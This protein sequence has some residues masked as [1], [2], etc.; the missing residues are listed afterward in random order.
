MLQSTSIFLHMLAN[1]KYCYCN[2][3][4]YI[5]RYC[6]KEKTHIR[7]YINCHSVHLKAFKGN[8]A[9]NQAGE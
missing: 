4:Q 6:N 5:R 9:A 8:N 7:K 1:I 3:R 2:L